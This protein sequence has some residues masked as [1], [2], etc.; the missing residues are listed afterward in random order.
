MARPLAGRSVLTVLGVLDD[1]GGSAGYTG[2]AS[3]SSPS[4]YICDRA[5]SRPASPPVLQTGI[6][7][8]LES[9]QRDER[10]LAAPRAVRLRVQ[11]RRH[12]PRA[13]PAAGGDGA[14][15]WAVRSEEPAAPI[16][17][18]ESQ[19]AEWQRAVYMLI[20]F[21]IRIY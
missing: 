19:N 4:V 12:H 6:G 5:A 18:E 3:A 9:G 17:D 21:V 11:R 10:W 2:T 15:R 8:P 13:D 20:S 16:R 14:A 7:L 1:T